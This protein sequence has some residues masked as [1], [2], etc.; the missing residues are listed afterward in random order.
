[1]KTLVLVLT[2]PHISQTDATPKGIVDDRKVYSRT[3]V[4]S[5]ELMKLGL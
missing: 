5:E 2:G 1:M 3:V 4:Y